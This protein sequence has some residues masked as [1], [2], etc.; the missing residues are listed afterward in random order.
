MSGPNYNIDQLLAQCETTE[1]TRR[2]L[3]T[4]GNSTLRLVNRQRPDVQSFFGVVYGNTRQRFWNGMTEGTNI[5]TT[6]SL[7]VYDGGDGVGPAQLTVVRNERASA[8]GMLPY[9]RYIYRPKAFVEMYGSDSGA[10]L[11][12][13]RGEVDSTMAE[14]DMPNQELIETQIAA[15]VTSGEAAPTPQD[16]VGLVRTLRLGETALD[17]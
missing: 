4:I 14:A 1:V 5:P 13:M 17:G 16:F 2:V 3:R 8:A 11:I 6:N 9:T 15:A 12:V 7:T 10:R